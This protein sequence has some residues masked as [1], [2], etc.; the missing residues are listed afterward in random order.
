M[1]FPEWNCHDCLAG[2]THFSAVARMHP[3]QSRRCHVS[4]MQILYDMHEFY[5]TAVHVLVVG[6][7]SIPGGGSLLAF[8]LPARVYIWGGRVGLE[9]TEGNSLVLV[10]ATTL[11]GCE[12]L[13]VL[14][15]ATTRTRGAAETKLPNVL[16]PRQCHRLLVVLEKV[17]ERAEQGVEAKVTKTIGWWAAMRRHYL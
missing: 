3:S 13:E 16:F 9:G 10:V 8:R 1:E 17:S 5:C 7:Y 11:N 12:A 6:S 15:S 2:A 4:C 14:Q